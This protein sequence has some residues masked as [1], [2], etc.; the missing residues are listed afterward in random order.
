MAV[1]GTWGGL[2]FGVSR[3]QI[4]TFN[5]LKWDISAKYATHDRHL[6]AALLEFTGTDLEEISFSMLFSVF[7]GTEPLTEINN[8]AAKV[9]AGTVDRLVIGSNPYGQSRW[10]IDKISNQLDKYDG[11]GNLW[12]A[13]VGITMKSYADR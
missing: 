3:N 10:V 5:D 4:K 6:K 12:A 2:V 1:I 7:L 9:R 13:K 8:L 11:K